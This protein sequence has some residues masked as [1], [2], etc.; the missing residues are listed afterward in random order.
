MVMLGKEI[1]FPMISVT[2][3]ATAIS[4]VLLLFMRRR[5]KRQTELIS[6]TNWLF[7]TVLVLLVLSTV[8]SPV[9][10]IETF[11]GSAFLSALSFA[12]V[13]CLRRVRAWVRY[14]V[15]GISFGLFIVFFWFVDPSGIQSFILISIFATLSMLVLFL[16]VHIKHTGIEFLPSFAK[17]GIGY[18]LISVIIGSAVAFFVSYSTLKAIGK[19]D[20]SSILQGLSESDKLIVQNSFP[21]Y[22]GSWETEEIEITDKETISRVREVITKARYK[23]RYIYGVPATKN[24]VSVK[25]YSGGREIGVFSIVSRCLSFKSQIIEYASDDNLLM[26]LRK[27][28]GAKQE[29]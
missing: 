4:F 14:L 11:I 26:L 3:I 2:V 5:Q 23:I 19:N 27:A 29:N 7:G 24:Y 22:D 28:V 18:I 21:Q 17:L 13:L 10:F 1:F 16:I 6:F 15:M 8:A 20:I 9:Y 25:M 12:V